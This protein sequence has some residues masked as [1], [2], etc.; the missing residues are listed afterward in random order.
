MIYKLQLIINTVKYLT[1]RQVFYRIFY[2]FYH[3][4]YKV[5]STVSGHPLKLK[6]G[7]PPACIQKDKSFTFLNLNKSF[8]DQID[9]N[10]SGHY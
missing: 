10:F 6:S 7:I 3:P 4:A 2:R 8:D 5:L 1:L 9:W